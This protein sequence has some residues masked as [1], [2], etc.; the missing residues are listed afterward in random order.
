[1]KIIETKKLKF[2]NKVCAKTIR[3]MIEK[4]VIIYVKHGEIIY[5][6]KYKEK[7][8]GKRVCEKVP[9]EKSIEFRPEEANN[10]S[11]Y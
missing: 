11:E 5:Q 8:N 3:N 2:K 4:G 6:K 10:R 7:N 1:M 9:A